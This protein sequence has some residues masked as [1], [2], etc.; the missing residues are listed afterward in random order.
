MAVF[1]AITTAICAIGW[2]KNH[3]T[4][5]TIT[6]YMQKKGYKLPDDKEVKEC[7][8]YVTKKIFGLK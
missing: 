5:L 4:A 2:Y 3:V 8:L 1:F 6:Y 7:T